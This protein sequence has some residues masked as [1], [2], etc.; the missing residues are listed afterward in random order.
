MNQR[1]LTLFSFVLFLLAAAAFAQF[2]TPDGEA[3]F[4][5]EGNWI[6]EHMDYPKKGAVAKSALTVA[7]P[8]RMVREELPEGG[9]RWFYLRQ[10]GPWE[11][12]RTGG[13]EYIGWGGGR[14]SVS[15]GKIRVD[16]PTLVLGTWGGISEVSALGLNTMRGKWTYRGDNNGGA[17][18][19]QRAVVKLERVVFSSR[20]VKT[21]ARPGAPAKV[22]VAYSGPGNNMRGNR[23]AF[24][25]FIYG[26]NLW[27]HHVIDL[28]GAVDLEPIGFKTFEEEVTGLGPESVVGQWF[29][30]MVW[31]R[32][33]PG[34]KTLWVDHQPIE[35]DLVVKGY[36]N[37]DDLLSEREQACENASE[38]ARG[39]GDEMVAPEF[40]DGWDTLKATGEIID[41]VA[42]DKPAEEMLK[43]SVD[44]L[45]ERM[46]REKNA[47]KLA[48]MEA[49][50]KRKLLRHL[51]SKGL[52]L[53]KK[54]PPITKAEIEA[55]KKM[56][57]F[58]PTVPQRMSSLVQTWKSVNRIYREGM[59]SYLRGRIG[60]A[61]TAKLF[62][63]VFGPVS[64]AMDIYEIYKFVRETEELKDAWEGALKSMEQ[65]EGCNYQLYEFR[66]NLTPEER[67]QI[68]DLRWREADY[69]RRRGLPP[70][71]YPSWPGE[72]IPPQ[73]EPPLVES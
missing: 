1:S 21:E 57:R 43:W 52:F 20:G 8:W 71:L 44:T 10:E 63:R 73:P 55:L 39:I 64:T 24:Y 62:S 50:Y 16:H 37:E 25:V 3:P 58:A 68:E 27:G 42:K 19:W 13:G 56:Y 41:E 40:W 46:L 53:N 51:Q 7:R 28:G 30:V 70:P 45:L 69:F 14:V 59:G 67:R 36:P 35:F 33:K 34:R 6:V 4:N 9:A 47:E 49:V 72:A 23:P 2:P 17:E 66:K 22:E 12:R 5:A 31:S 38:E 60:R 18:V 29:I 15:S 54:L 48:R 26:E 61:F 11:L 65:A 32:A